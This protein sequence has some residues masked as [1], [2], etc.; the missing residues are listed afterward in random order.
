MQDR[1]DTD[2]GVEPVGDNDLGQAIL[3][4]AK[5]IIDRVI[6]R[7]DHGGSRNLFIDPV[8]GVPLL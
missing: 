4:V 2:Q 8:R 6:F 3:V 7:P 5:F 1:V